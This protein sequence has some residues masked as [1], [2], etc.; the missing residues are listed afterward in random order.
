MRRD[1]RSPCAGIRWGPKPVSPT[2]NPRS[3]RTP[4][5]RQIT[6]SRFF[7]DS[8]ALAMAL[9][10]P[11]WGTCDSSFAGAE[12]SS[13]K[14]RATSRALTGAAD[15]ASI[16]RCGERRPVLYCLRAAEGVSA[17]SRVGSSGAPAFLA[18]DTWVAGEGGSGGGGTVG[19]GGGGG[20]GGGVPPVS[21]LCFLSG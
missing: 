13:P 4:P 10:S 16:A 8:Q 18:S 5:L 15:H 11:A 21:P 12:L 19:A 17:A 14:S 6:Y 7:Q 9:C 3:G 20:S 2:M 1:S